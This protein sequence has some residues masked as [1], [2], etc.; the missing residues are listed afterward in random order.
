MITINNLL[1][2]NP[3]IN[4]LKAVVYKIFRSRMPSTV[5]PLVLVYAR[6]IIEKPKESI[7]FL[8]SWSIDNRMALKVLIDK[9]LLQ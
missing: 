2:G 3:D 5:Q 7:N 6:M 9:W 4:L 8:T 1:D